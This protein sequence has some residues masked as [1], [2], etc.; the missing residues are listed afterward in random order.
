MP[1]VK[2]IAGTRLKLF[3]EAR[4]IAGEKNTDINYELK[5][6]NCS[7]HPQ[8]VDLSHHPYS[9]HVMNAR[10]NPD[11]LLLNPGEIKSTTVTVNVTDRVPPGG[12]ERQ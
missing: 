7:D 12:R 1:C 3:S 2:V 5:V 8:S 9:K 11:R 6:M 4:S 10:I